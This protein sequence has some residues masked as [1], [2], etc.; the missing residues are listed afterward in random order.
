[1][2]GWG[3]G[4]GEGRTA[5]S[6]PE[7]FDSLGSFI[8]RLLLSS[9]I[10]TTTIPLIRRVRSRGRTCSAAHRPRPGGRGEVV[11]VEPPG[12]EQ[13]VRLELLALQPRL[14]LR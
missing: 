12:G 13:A 11:G 14:P 9:M 10:V 3:V 7:G 8:R 1:M 4:A 5:A 6:H 2:D